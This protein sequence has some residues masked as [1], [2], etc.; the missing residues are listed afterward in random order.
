MRYLPQDIQSAIQAHGVLVS[1]SVK[2]AD[3]NNVPGEAE[4]GGLETYKNLWENNATRSTEEHRLDG[5][6]GNSE[7]GVRHSYFLG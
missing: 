2:G 1:H 3:S 6:E 5:G 7:Q 4:D